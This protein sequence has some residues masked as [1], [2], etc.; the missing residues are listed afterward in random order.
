MGTDL[1]GS[2]VLVI[3]QV[4]P[5]PRSSAAGRRMMQLL[6]FFKNQR[7]EIHF[8]SVALPTDYSEDLVSIG[9]RVLQLRLNCSSVNQVFEEIAPDFVVFDRFMTEE[10]FGWRIRESCPDTVRILDTEDLHFLRYAREEQCKKG[11]DLKEYL[12]SDRAKREIGAIMRSDLSLI[13]SEFEYQLL[14]KTFKVP[15]NALFYLPF[16]ENVIYKARGNEWLTFEER[17]DFIFIGN[18]IHEPNWQTVLR[19]KREIWPKLRNSISGVQIRIYGAYATAKVHQMH[20]EKEGFWVCGRAEEANKVLET[21]RVLLA[22]IPFGA[23]IKGKFLDAIEVGTPSVTTAIGAEGM[24]DEIE[25][26]GFVCQTNEEFIDKAIRLYR[27]K[28]VWQKAQHRGVELYNKRF[29][30]K[31]HEPLLKNRLMQLKRN[32]ASERKENFM[33]QVLQHHQFQSTKYMSLWIEEKNKK[34]L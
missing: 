14:Q 32:V 13:I 30:R 25:W 1:K 5:E 31:Q 21:A 33:G 23:G 26:G 7:A 19:I 18:F 12:F 20:D 17:K 15:S 29:D 34:E 6:T 9:I 11:G 2:R 16:L 3:G 8:A 10:Q 24:G 22:P 4:W 28:E 27:D